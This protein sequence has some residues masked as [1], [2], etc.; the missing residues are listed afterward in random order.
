[1]KL[2]P[3][4]IKFMRDAYLVLFINTRTMLVCAA[5][6]YSEPRPSLQ[7]NGRYYAVDIMRVTGRDYAEA[8][9]TILRSITTTGP[10]SWILPILE[11]SP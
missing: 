4:E 11:A 6:I 7:A 3:V 9:A 2:A 5:D 1:M 10:L 8:R